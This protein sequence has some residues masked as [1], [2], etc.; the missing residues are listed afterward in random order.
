MQLPRDILERRPE[1]GAR[2]IAL[3][4]LD[5]ARAAAARL[6]D[7][8]DAEALH[9]FR[10]AVRRLRSTVRAYKLPLGRA[11]RK[12]DRAALKALQEATGGG[13]D[14]EVFLEWLSH[15]KGTLNA[16]QKVGAG[17]LEARLAARKAGA[18]ASIRDEVAQAFATVEARLRERLSVLQL[19]V[20]LEADD[21]GA[22]TFGDLCATLVVDHAE[23]LRDG[24]LRVAG[25]DDEETAHRTR[26]LGKRFRYLLEPLAPLD[27]AVPGMV[28]RCKKLQSVLGDL[29]DVHVFARELGDAV[30]V[31][32]AEQARRLHA[33]TLESGGDPEVLRRATRKNE[34][35]GLLALTRQAKDQADGLYEAF[36]GRWAQGGADELVQEAEALAARLSRRSG[37]DLEIERKYLLRALPEAA[38]EAPSVRLAQG[39]LPGDK[40]RERLRRVDD[41]NGG[42]RFERTVKLGRGL[43]RIEVQEPT[44]QEVFDGLWP[45]TEGCR[46]EKRRYLVRDEAQAPGL[47]FEVDEFLDRELVLAEVELPSAE[48]EVT[49]PDWLA[50]VVEREVTD[51]PAYVNLNLAR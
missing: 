39:W 4:H 34:R 44:S 24:V 43:T 2:R 23:A 29:H 28:K 1:E 15:Q 12:K 7:P 10:V 32:A 18:M 5:E 19:T 35:T 42:V 16:G 11:V 40:L 51:D 48:V 26:I 41:G 25:P 3:G 47:V 46:V 38:R 27:E 17:W 13:R 8:K 37:V 33:L 20:D 9:D 31:A 22:P 14:A 30:G 49:L 21:G 36:D 6:G 45:L 50:A